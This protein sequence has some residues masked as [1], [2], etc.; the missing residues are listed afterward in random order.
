MPGLKYQMVQAAK[1]GGLKSDFF[2]ARLLTPLGVSYEEAV[3]NFSPYNEIKHV[4]TKMR[5]DTRRLIRRG[6][7]L[8]KDVYILV[9]NRCEGNAPLTIKALSI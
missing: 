1:A 3:K 5:E 7:E 8:G 6:T 9:N 4:N 2:I